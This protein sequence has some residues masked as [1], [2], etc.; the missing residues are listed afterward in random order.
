MRVRRRRSF[1]VSD[2]FVQSNVLRSVAV[3]IV[4]ILF[5]RLVTHSRLTD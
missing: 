4:D 2:S 5:I 1:E 3:L